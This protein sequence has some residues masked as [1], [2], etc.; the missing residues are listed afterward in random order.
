MKHACVEKFY[1]FKCPLLRGCHLE[2]VN[3][4]FSMIYHGLDYLIS[5]SSTRVIRQNT[6]DSCRTVVFV[7]SSLL[8]YNTT[9]LIVF[10]STRRLK[11]R[12]AAYRVKHVFRPYI[13]PNRVPSIEISEMYGETR[14]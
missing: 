14:T 4:T 3:Q 13:D 6:R 10:N 9:F 2:F 11:P 7:I 12:V 5:I 8:Y 1:F